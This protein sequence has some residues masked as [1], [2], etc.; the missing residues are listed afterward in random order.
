MVAYA[1]AHV[2]KDHVFK[3][4]DV[5][6]SNQLQTVLFTPDAPVQTYRVAV[7][8]GNVTD[9]DSAAWT[10][11]LVGIQDNGAGSLGAA[12]RAGAGDEMEVEYQPRAGTGQDKVVATIRGSEITF[13]GTAGQFRT[14]DQTFGVVGAPVFSQSS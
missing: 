14:F 10:L 12:L 8:D 1:R 7:P 3:L 5:D 6:Y 11:Q 13:G 4:D 9:T 2:V